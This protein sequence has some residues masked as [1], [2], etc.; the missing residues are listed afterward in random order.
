MSSVNINITFFVLRLVVHQQL[1]LRFYK[2]AVMTFH[3]LPNEE[4]RRNVIHLR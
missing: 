1:F 3:I 2:T 4:I